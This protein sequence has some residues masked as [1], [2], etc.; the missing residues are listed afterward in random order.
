MDGLVSDG[1]TDGKMDGWMDHGRRMGG[2]R[3][4]CIHRWSNERITENI[5]HKTC[6]IRICFRVNS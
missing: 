3:D 5:L 1:C 4:E 2:R 6:Y